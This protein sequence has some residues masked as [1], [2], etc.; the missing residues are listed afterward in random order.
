MNGKWWADGR[1]E[2]E[3]EKGLE[4]QTGEKYQDARQ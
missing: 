1:E 3:Q 4:Q 2:Q